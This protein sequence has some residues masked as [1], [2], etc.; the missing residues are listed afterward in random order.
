[1]NT[2]VPTNVIVAPLGTSAYQLTYMPT[3]PITAPSSGATQNSHNSALAQS[4]TRSAGPV[5]RAY[6]RREASPSNHKDLANA[7][8]LSRNRC[9]FSAHWWHYRW[10]RLA[11]LQRDP[12]DVGWRIHHYYIK[13]QEEFLERQNVSRGRP[14]DPAGFAQKDASRN[15]VFDDAMPRLLDQ[16]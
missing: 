2:K 5:L 10:P 15:A 9:A 7:A 1:M 11:R 12:A 6:T 14:A 8:Y 4:P 13:S 16:L 3:N